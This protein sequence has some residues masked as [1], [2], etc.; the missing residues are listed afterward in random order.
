MSEAGAAGADRLVALRPSSRQMPLR[1]HSL[2]AIFQFMK[3]M[4]GVRL[5]QLH[6]DCGMVG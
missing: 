3:S 5:R 4:D 1:D 2:S 6:I